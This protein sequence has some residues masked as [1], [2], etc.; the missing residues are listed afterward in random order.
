M[1]KLIMFDIGGVITH[2]DFQ[3]LYSD[4]ATRIGVSSKFVIDYHKE[5]LN[6]LLLGNKTLDNFWEDMKKESLKELDYQQIWLEEALKIRQV[7]N[8]LLDIIDKLREKHKVC[9][10]TNLTASRLIIDQAQKL[11]PHFDANLLSCV[12]HLK[13]PDPEFYQ[14]ALSKFSVTPKETLFVDDKEN[15]IKAGEGVGIRGII[16]LNKNKL[17]EELTKFGVG[18]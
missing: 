1:I 8:E 7:D 6:D 16:Y 12:E 14:L 18:F 2:T 11:Y 5:N 17:L 13:K 4:F 9:T 15:H 10:L 3:K